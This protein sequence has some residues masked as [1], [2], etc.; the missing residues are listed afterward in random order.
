MRLLIVIPISAMILATACS[1]SV[2]TV[3]S[4]THVAGPSDTLDERG[5]ING[6]V[7]V[8]IIVDWGGEVEIFGDT[9]P[10]E[11]ARERLLVIGN[12]NPSQPVLI[13]ADDKIPS[14]RVQEIIDLCKTSHLA[15]VVRIQKL[16]VMPPPLPSQSQT[17]GT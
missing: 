7:P 1:R 8:V 12:G 15:H 3:K 6:Y 10:L 13:V 14:E 4:A 9:F 11:K 2:D 5:L 17:A 16:P